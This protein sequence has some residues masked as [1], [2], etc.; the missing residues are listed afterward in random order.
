M[1]VELYKEVI[2]SLVCNGWK[3]SAVGLAG[4]VSFVPG[5]LGGEV[6]VAAASVGKACPSNVT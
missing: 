5:H 6:F 2:G 1:R 4:P 3:V